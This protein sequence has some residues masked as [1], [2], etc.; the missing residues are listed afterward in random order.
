MV[1]LQKYIT[2]HGPTKVKRNIIV[3]R[4][5]VKNLHG[6]NHLEIIHMHGKT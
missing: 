1:L 2:M 5:L 4:N 6:G 3:Y